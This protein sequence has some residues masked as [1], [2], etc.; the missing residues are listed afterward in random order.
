M[1]AHHLDLILTARA[2]FP[3]FLQ[4]I[5]FRRF[6]TGFLLSCF[7]ILL[8]DCGL[9]Y[10]QAHRWRHRWRHRWGWWGLA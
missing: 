4:L 1:R 2:I 5:K 10:L 8:R 3:V 6:P 7:L 9:L